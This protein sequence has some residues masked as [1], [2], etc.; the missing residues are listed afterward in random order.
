MLSKTI[1]NVTIYF[2]PLII[3]GGLI[4]I[5]LLVQLVRSIIIV[6]RFRKVCK[7]VLDGKYDDVIKIGTK[8]LHTYKK[9]NRRLRTKQLA[10]RI[11]KVNFYLS[12]SYFSTSDDV[13]FLS[14]INELITYVN[15]KEFWLA[16]FYLQKEDFE[17]A[18]THYDLIACDETTYVARTFLDALKSYKK[19]EVSIAKKKMAEV[20]NELNYPIL[21]QIAHNIL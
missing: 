12:V 2:E 3:Y 16:L 18:Q 17:T 5:I 15:I 13:Q 20:V 8:L 1:G 6:I 21:K 11:E 14:H 7:N 10:D 4:A 19:Q 9:Y